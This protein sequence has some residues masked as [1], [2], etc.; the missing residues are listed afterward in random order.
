MHVF[1]ISSIVFR[2]TFEDTLCNLRLVFERL[3]DANLTL[4]PK[5]CFLFQESVKFLGHIVSAKGIHCDPDKLRSVTDWPH[6]ENITDLRSFLGTASYYR[7][8]IP[9]FSTI[10][11]PLT[12]LTRKDVKFKWSEAEDTAFNSLKTLL[13]SAPILSFPR[14]KGLYI[15]DCDASGTG[16]G[17]VLSQIQ[18]GEERVIAYASQTK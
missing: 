15:L 11:A 13:I 8:F 9:D 18:D 10:A 2:K 6:P 3:R 12:D 1:H 16:I 14:E 5:K 17:S 7:R 4:K